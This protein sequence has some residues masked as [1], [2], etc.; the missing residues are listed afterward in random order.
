VEKISKGADVNNHEARISTSA[1]ENFQPTWYPSGLSR[2]QKRK[3]QRAR[4]KKF[5]EEGLIKMGKQIF[6]KVQ[7]F[8][9][10]SKKEPAVCSKSAEPTPPVL[11]AL[12]DP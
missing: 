11:A 12:A 2:T 5:K 10:S 9:Q 1:L 7:I 4:C 3:L 8:P 6:N